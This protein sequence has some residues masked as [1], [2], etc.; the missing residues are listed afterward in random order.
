MGRMARRQANPYSALLRSRPFARFWIGFTVSA[1][2][3]AMTR[4]AL[5][6]Y[7]YQT[8]NSPAAVGILLLCYTGPVLV[9][10]L[11]AGSL[12][13]RFDRGRVMLVDNAIR[14]LA[15]G[16]IPLLQAMGLLALWHLYAVAAVYGF[17]YMIT[18]AGTPALIPALVAD[19]TQLSAANALETLSYTLTGVLGP[20]LAGVL[21]V[22]AG[23]PSVLL[24]DG[25]SY[26]L[27]VLALLGAPRHQPAHL[28]A[29]STGSDPAPASPIR[30]YRLQDALALTL[31]NR[32]LLSTTLMFM[33]FNV[34]LGFLSVWLPVLADHL[35]DSGGAA[36]YGTL[37][38]ALAFGEMVGAV[39]AGAIAASSRALGVLIC[40]TQILS[41]LSLTLLP[42]GKSV[43]RPVW[44]AAVGLALLGVF[45]APLT[46]W[47]QT[48]RMQIIPAELRG[49][50]FALLR[51]LMQGAGPLASAAAGA[52]LP[53]VG[54]S[55][56]VA[57]SAVLIGGPGLLGARVKAL[58]QVM[59]APV[60]PVAPV[61]ER[62]SPA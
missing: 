48:L 61:A 4:V 3:D 51:T 16:S 33:L 57:A 12:L 38:G 17:L 34:G 40:G 50:T 23:A 11:L 39:L 47:A 54:V 13:D 62:G 21:I 56:L 46:I 36:L 26:A 7:V 5:I 6:W 19:N 9:G 22:A 41:G 32:V 53:L 59:A 43:G 44:G 27:F 49:R 45:S 18:L 24:L 29:T 60:A 42:V 52:M 28:P 58:R 10:G 2:G 55:A 8:T 14:G 1:L 30:A 15:I 31:S 37:L 35:T 25:A 20:P